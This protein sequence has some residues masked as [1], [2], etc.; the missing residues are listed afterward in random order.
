MKIEKEFRDDHQVKLT[1]ELDQEPFEKAKHRAARQIAKRVKVPGFRPGKAPYGVILRQVGEGHV[2][3]QALELLVEEQYPEIIK[4]AEIKPYGPGALENVVELDPPTFEFV[5]P[6]AAEIELGDYKTLDIPFE[7]PLIS[8]EELNEALA[9]I[10][11]QNAVRESVDRPAQIGDVV[12]MRVSGK[13]TDVEDE[14][15]ATM[16]E[17][18]FSSSKIQEDADPN[19]WPFPG[20]SKELVGL[21]KDGEKTIGY[22]FPDDHS[23]E[24][25]QGAAVDYQV[26]V[27]NVQSLKLPEIDDEL[28][29]TAS[30]FE[31]L[32]E[33]KADLKKNLEENSH[34]T[35]AEE[36][37]DQVIDHIVSS[38]T[39]KFPPQMIE[40]EKAEILRSLDYRLSQQGISK[41]QYLQIRRINDEQLAEE[42][43][44]VADQRIQ[45]ALV[46][47]E[48]AKAEDIQT[49]PDMVQAEMGR[50]F[51][52]I[53]SSMSPND[54]KKF[55]KSDYLPSLANNIV[56]DLLT[57]ATM[58][59]LRATAK[60]EPWPPEEETTIEDVDEAKTAVEPDADE[61]P[62]QTQD[63][64]SFT[65]IEPD[66]QES[67]MESEENPSE[68]ED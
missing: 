37:D 62:E 66:E 45:R 67:A 3:E 20:F 31:T 55:A 61:V 22:Q 65:Q 15:E 68:A 40:R 38:S 29:K 9:K 36:Y 63:D 48:I 60:G 19:E 24:N 33:W 53:S 44:P 14:A 54:A 35:Y 17:D 11:E 32:E 25:L 10:Q 43:S 39:V 21:S 59:Y 34:A 27:T 6:L 5:I 42:I 18:R 4:E 16:V 2:V 50:T 13:R 49:D 46:L 41:D 8:D 64:K 58:N 47:M 7:P 30:E 1:V 56:A 51:Q 12:Y 23:E 52:A 28:A 57:Q 26:V